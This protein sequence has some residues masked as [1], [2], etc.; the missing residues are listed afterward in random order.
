MDVIKN[1]RSEKLNELGRANHISY[2]KFCRLV[3]LDDDVS[4]VFNKEFLVMLMPIS[5]WL[6]GVAAGIS[7]L[8]GLTGHPYIMCCCGYI[9]GEIVI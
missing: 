1:V 3:F 7:I 8:K 9:L 5:L 2:G 6:M 4:Q